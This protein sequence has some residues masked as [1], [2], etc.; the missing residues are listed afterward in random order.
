MGKFEDYIRT[1]DPATPLPTNLLTDL[2]TAYAE[3]IALS[4]AKISS[5]EQTLTA[6]DEEITNLSK[7]L[8]SAKSH[9]YDLLMSLPK[10]VDEIP[11]N[12]SD[13]TTTIDDLF[14]VENGT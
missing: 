10:K 9:N 1:I 2:Q 8:T 4:D 13:E 7:E 12:P 5:V 6:K 3:D 14:G 11:P